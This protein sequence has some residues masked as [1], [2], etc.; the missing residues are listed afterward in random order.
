AAQKLEQVNATI[1]ELQ[2]SGHIKSSLNPV[3]LL[4]SVAEQQE[5]II[6]WQQFWADGKAERALEAVRNAAIKSG[7]STEAFAPF[8]QTLKQ[9]YVPFDSSA[10]AFLQTLMPANFGSS[11]GQFYNIATLKVNPNH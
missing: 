6:R 10:V 8:E 11:Q 2:N 4:P 9:N 5:R 1:K 3:V 7:F